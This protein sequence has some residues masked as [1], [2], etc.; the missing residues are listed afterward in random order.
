MSYIP[1]K[2]YGSDNGDNDIDDKSS[3]ILSIIR[4]I[5]SYKNVFVYADFDDNIEYYS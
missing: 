1:F 5:V 2:I 3:I 4:E